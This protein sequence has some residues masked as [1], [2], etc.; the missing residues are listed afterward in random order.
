M[1]FIF[2][3]TLCDVVP[4]LAYMTQR[5]PTCNVISR[6]I[7]AILCLVGESHPAYRIADSKGLPSPKFLSN[8]SNF[9]LQDIRLGSL[10][11]E[12]NLL[13]ALRDLLGELSEV[14]ALAMLAQWA[15]D[16]REALEQVFSVVPPPSLDHLPPRRRRGRPKKLP[17]P[18]KPPRQIG[19]IRAISQSTSNEG[20]S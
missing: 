9:D 1:P 18:P 16:H 5:C 12:S 3:L 2:L 10:N 15:M 19:F 4:R 17:V 6:P 13:K 11:R 14:T 7:A 8:L 20:T